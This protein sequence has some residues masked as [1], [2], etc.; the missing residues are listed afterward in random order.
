MGNRGLREGAHRVA[1][2]TNLTLSSNNNSFSL[3]SILKASIL[4]SLL[5]ILKPIVEQAPWLAAAYRKYRDTRQLNTAP[6]D[7]PFGFKLSSNNLMTEG[8]FE[9]EETSIVL[10]IL[11][12]VN[13]VIN[14]GANIGYY[15]CMAQTQGKQVMAFEP[16]PLN[17]NYLLR[18]IRTNK[19]TEL[20][21]VFGMALSDSVGIVD[22]FGGSH[23]AS[24]IK[25]WENTTTKTSTLVPSSTLDRII[26]N[27]FSNQPSLIIVDIEGAE[28]AMLKGSHEMLLRN[29]KPVWLVEI[30]VHEHQ[31]R[32]VSV[33]PTLVQTFDLFWN[34]GYESWTATNIPRL[35]SRLEVKAMAEVGPIPCALITLFSVKL[36]PYILI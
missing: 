21:E 5:S 28:Y 10:E 7:T 6:K 30:S 11:P 4:K 15:T 16:L 36:A 29:W 20:V 24:L 31:P 35:V 23:G 33:N 14:V 9:P 34:N 25:G 17:Q 27:R 18:N 3:S 12:H 22:I 1:C 13:I 19:N 32:G 8:H 26:G 2:H